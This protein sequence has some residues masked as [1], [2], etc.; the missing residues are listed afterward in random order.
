VKAVSNGKYTGVTLLQPGMGDGFSSPLF[1]GATSYGNIYGAGLANAFTGGGFTL[2]CWA[3]VSGA[4]VWTD[5]TL[6]RIVYLAVDVNNRVYFER[7][8]TDNRINY[9]F[10]GGGITD[11]VALTSFSPTAWFHLAITVSASDN[12]IKALINGAQT[13]ATQ[14][15]VGVWAGLLAATST[16]IGAASTTPANVY[17]GTI[18]HAAIWNTPLSRVQISYLARAN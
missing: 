1:D 9:V 5:A 7:S 18:A 10:A 14:T 16:L 17:S 4:G 6:R 13:G 8:T 11:S 2:A 3:K 15:G 12:A